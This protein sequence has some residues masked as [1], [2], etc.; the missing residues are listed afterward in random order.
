MSTATTP[1]QEGFDPTQIVQLGYEPQWQS[2]QSVGTFYGGAA[3]IY[4]GDAKGSYE[5]DYSRQLEGRIPVVTM[6]ACGANS[7]SSRTGPL[8]ARRNLAPATSFN[9]GRAA[10][11]LTQTWYTCCLGELVEAGNEF[12]LGI[13]PM[14]SDGEVH[15]RIDADTFRIWK[16]TKN[17]DASLHC[18]GLPDH[19]RR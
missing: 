5:V 11:G 2:I 10:M 14:G 15:G 4:S 17:P 18:L 9:S 6:M 7:P 3:K 13:Q 1:S 8:L 19:H 12:Q 16:G